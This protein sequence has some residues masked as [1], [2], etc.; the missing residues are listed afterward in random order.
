MRQ[1]KTDYGTIILHWTFV[2]AFAVALVTG[3]R[4]ATET[5]DRTWINWFDAVL[6]RDSVWIAHMQA[7]I[8]LVAVAIGYIVYMVRSGLGRRVQLDKVRLRGLFGRG[9]ARLSAVIALM[10]WIFFV[11]MLGLL[12]SGGAL[13]F[14]FYSGYDVAMLHWVGT[15]VILA[16]VVLHVLTQYKSGG[17]SQL[18]R[19][20]RPAPLPAPPPRLDAV[21][22]LGLLAERS[23]R[24]PES[25][26]LDAPPEVPHP[27]QPRADM[28]R[29]RASEADP[30]PRPPAGPARSRNPTLQA[31][32]FVVAAAAAITG[33]SLIVATDRLAVD[34]VQI[35]RIN[36][37]DAPS[38]DGD[39]SDRAWRGVKPFSLLTG[40]GGNFDGKGEAR[41]EIRAVHD[42]TYAYFL[43]TWQDSTR[44]LKHLPLVKEGDGWHLLHSGFQLGD[45]HQ[46]N[47]DKFSVLLTTSDVTLAGGRTFHPGPQPVAGAPATMSGRGLHY[48]AT[49]YADVWQWKATSG[50]TGWMDDAH[51]GPPLNPT[52]MQA[53]NVVPYKGGFAPD[54]GTASY[55]DNFTVEA[56]TSGGPRRSR[57]VAP[58]RLPKVV[59]ATTAALGDIDLDPNH[60]ESDGA[61]WF[62]TD[63]DSVPYSTDTDARIPTGTVIPGV[64]LGGEFSGDRADVRSAARWASGHWALEVKRRLDTVSQFDVPI[65]TGVF[66]RVAAFDHSQIRHTRHVRPIRIEVE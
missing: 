14:G 41:I 21:E 17:A 53:A 5:P 19:I 20:F 12:V 58:L 31:N 39:T 25:E 47:E 65:K 24:P 35:R 16:F 34:S 46:Y 63:Q 13:Y 3:L 54:P 42:G 15:W 6:P 62:M 59:A 40:E 36:P 44:S 32:A 56:D 22:L 33:A 49:G 27:L 11:T 60:G 4:I 64:I 10:Y 23:A 8:V 43:F 7:A 30:A 2:A 9:Q 26:N 50:A 38:L 29:D 28:R 52:P 48:T 18:L 37:A 61:R 51:F 66:M 1:R 55:R 57:L 45:E